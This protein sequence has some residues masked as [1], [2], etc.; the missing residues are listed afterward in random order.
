MHYCGLWCGKSLVVV[1][2][3]TTLY[4]RICGIKSK[5]TKKNHQYSTEYYLQCIPYRLSIRFNILCDLRYIGSLIKISDHYVYIF[6]VNYRLKYFV[7]SGI[8]L[9]L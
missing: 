8:E 3:L 5:S 6:S 2:F 1:E 4:I 7:K 9:N